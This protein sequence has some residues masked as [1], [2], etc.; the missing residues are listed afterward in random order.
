M[1][2]CYA[3]IHLNLFNLGLVCALFALCGAARTQDSQ[4]QKFSIQGV[5]ASACGLSAPRT[6]A[7]QNMAVAP[8]GTGQNL[9]TIG[10]LIDPATALLQP[11]SISL[12]IQGLCNQAHVVT[13]SSANGG[14][15][16]QGA[17]GG[18]ANVG[19]ATRIDYGA[20]VTWA[21]GSA[22]FRTQGIA[23]QPVMLAP[24]PGAYSGALGLQI[25]IDVSGAGGI[26]VAAGT[27]TD[28]ITITLAPQL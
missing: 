23:R 6:S 4:L 21:G 18:G 11:G 3:F 13:V 22:S 5:A 26:P 20:Q 10:S 12:S 14:L 9:V 27:Y 7:A 16:W 17:S 15:Q 8:I 19:F 2:S 1:R 28:N 24:V 25:A